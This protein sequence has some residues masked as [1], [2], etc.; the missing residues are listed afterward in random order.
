M[1]DGFH[2][3]QPRDHADECLIEFGMDLPVYEKVSERSAS[4]CLIIQVYAGGSYPIRN[5]SD[6]N[7][8]ARKLRRI[9]NN[10]CVSRQDGWWVRHCIRL[11]QSDENTLGCFCREN[12]FA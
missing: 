6:P 8:I 4:L 10:R 5:R 3:F 9:G 12:W 11:R 7:L 2:C 1:L